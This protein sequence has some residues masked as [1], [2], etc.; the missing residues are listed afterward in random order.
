MQPC[1]LL[2]TIMLSVAHGGFVRD[3][4]SAS[5]N[6]LRWVRTAAFLSA[7]QLK[8]SV[9]LIAAAASIGT[10]ALPLMGCTGCFTQQ[11]RL[12]LYCKKEK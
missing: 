1:T 5:Q 9:D 2:Q 8:Q 11:V 4:K 3:P 6:S 10:E 12:G 7:M